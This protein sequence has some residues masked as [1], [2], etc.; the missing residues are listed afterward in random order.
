M[1]NVVSNQRGEP[2]MTL[3]ALMLVGGRTPAE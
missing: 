1:R 3:D 2:V